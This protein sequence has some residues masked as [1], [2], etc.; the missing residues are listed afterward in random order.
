MDD[1]APSRP[2]Q[3][4][5]CK[6][7]TTAIEAEARKIEKYRAIVYSGYIFQSNTMEILGSL[8]ESSKNF[9]LCL[10]KMLC[11]A[12]NNLKQRISM[13]LQIGKAACVLGTLSDRDAFE[14]YYYMYSSFVKLYIFS[15]FR[16]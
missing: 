9:L 16:C 7:G 5:L 4:P 15:S 6:P 8:G 13:A 1:P 2:N 11:C 14:E 3:G 10:R 12:G